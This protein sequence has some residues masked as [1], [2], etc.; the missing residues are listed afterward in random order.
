MYSSP[1]A[2]VQNPGFVTE[3]S[4]NPQSWVFDAVSLANFPIVPT[5]GAAEAN[6]A[7]LAQIILGTYFKIAKVAVSVSAIEDITDHSFNIVVGTGAY[8][9]GTIGPNDDSYKYG[10]PQHFATSGDAVFAADVVFDAANFPNG[11]A[12]GTGGVAV[13]QPSQYN[14]IYPPGTILTLR[15]TTP[16]GGSITNLLVG[17]AGKVIDADIAVDNSVPTVGW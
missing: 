13:L 9:Q 14:A 5:V 8:V 3:K 17:L 4:H 7:V 6:T 15:A 16:G 10:Y 12:T 1:L 11:I 2:Q